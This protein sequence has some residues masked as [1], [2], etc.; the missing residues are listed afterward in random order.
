MKKYIFALF[1][2]L[3]LIV[4]TYI[5]FRHDDDKA[6]NVLPKEVTAVAVL[7]PAE[8]F[9]DLGLPVE[10]MSKLPLNFEGIMESVDLTKPIYAFATEK[11]LT[12]VAMNVKDA[13]KLLQAVSVF[14]YATE[15][16]QGFHWIVNNNSIGCIDE[17]KMLLLG[18]VA[19]AEQD[20]LRPEMLKLMNQKRQDVPVLDK[21]EEQ[22]GVILVSSSL[23]NLPTQYTKAMPADP[24]LSKAFLNMALRIDEKAIRLTTKVEGIDK[25]DM[26]MSPIEGNLI[27]MEPKE[28]FAWIAFN[29]KGE[30]LLPNLRQEPRLRSALLALNMCVDADMMIKAI[31]GDV[32]IALPKADMNNPDFILTAMLSNTEFLK[33]AEDW[34]VNRRS[35]TDF[36]ITQNGFSVYFGVREQKLYIASS[37]EL[38]NK[39]CQETEAEDFQ[40]ESKGKYLTASLDTDE[41]LEQMFSTPSLMSLMFTMPQIR[42]VADA[43]ERVTITADSPQ[44]FELSIETDEPVKDIIS[45]ISYLL[46][47]DKI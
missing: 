34:E 35:T 8:L 46:T 17:D 37:E 38:A 11:G 5:Y 9:L 31:D 21:A 32:S 23:T 30:D 25:L 4:A 28:P 12:G 24:D 2:L 1:C 45:K 7:K 19:S 40:E 13:D 36:S 10:K 26:P 39:A 16:Q 14:S 44:S 22:K 27:H 43:F 29:T 42:E 18:P 41:L 6:R 47:G 15:E 3:F 20:A 33:N